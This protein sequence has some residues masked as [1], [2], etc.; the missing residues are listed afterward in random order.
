MTVDLWSGVEKW[1]MHCG[2][3]AIYLGERQHFLFEKGEV[4]GV[5]L[6]RLRVLKI[7]A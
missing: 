4:D 3:E 2:Y 1:N 7:S 5:L 6:S